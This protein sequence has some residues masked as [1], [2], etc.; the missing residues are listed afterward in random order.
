MNVFCPN[1]VQVVPLH[2]KN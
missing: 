2:S 1:F